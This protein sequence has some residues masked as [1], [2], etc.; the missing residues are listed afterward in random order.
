MKKQF[1]LKT[2]I[3][4]ML[5]ASALTCTLMLLIVALR[6]GLG[7][8]LFNEIRTYIALRHKIEASYI[9]DY[10]SK[11]VSE[12]ALAAAVGA[13]DDRWSYYLTP[14]EYAE[15]INNSN[16]Q[17]YGVGINVAKDEQ[18][19]GLVILDVYA[20]SSADKAG[21]VAGDIITVIDGTRLTADMTLSE[22][23][24]LI[25]P[26][27]GQSVRLTLL[28]L[29]GATR[30]VDIA[31]ALIETDP[32]TYELLDGGIGYI[33]IDNFEAG[34]A[35]GFKSALDALIKDGALS[36]IYDLRNNRGG[37]VSELKQI[38]DRLLPD[39]EIFVAVD[40]NG[41]Q[42]VS[43]SDDIELEMPAVVLVNG[44]SFSAAEYFAAVLQEYDYA[45][46]VGQPTTGKSRSQITLELP[47][48]GALHI[49]SG[50][51]LTPDR[52]SLTEQ[53]G[54]EPDIV[55]DMSDEDTA[56]LYTGTLDHADD[57]QLQ[58]AIGL[59]DAAG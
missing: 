31:Y 25:D 51:Y 35:E 38:L 33:Q 4:L 45:T 2:V 5:A 53:G 34:A 23:S 37:R 56:R 29:D 24:G 22:A 18:T 50:E 6:L 12:A 40:E 49:S 30:E 39:C 43:Y 36:F 7:T 11:S 46:V 21:I 54:L 1:G 42:D 13:L 19:G 52:V 32:V 47:D 44:Y 16:N 15:Y 41:T 27:S 14:E 57:S 59:L 8:G 28:G 48:G 20:G 3:A 10:D 9:G 55:I 58:K 17:Y 26:K